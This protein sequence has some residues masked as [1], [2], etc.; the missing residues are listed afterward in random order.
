MNI[1][2]FGTYEEGYSRNEIMIKSLE[3]LGHTVQECHVSFWRGMTDKTGTMSGK[4]NR[5]RILFRILFIYPRLFVKYIFTRQHDLVFVGYF[6]HLDMIFLRLFNLILFRQ[7][8]IVFDVFLSLYDSMIVDRKMD[9]GNSMLARL[10]KWLDKTAC[11]LADVVILD[12]YRHIEFF[13]K[14][15]DVPREKMF[16]VYASADEDVF[17]PRDAKKENT[18]FRVLFYGKYIPLHGIEHIVDAAELLATDPEIRFTLIG[19]GQLYPEIRR[20]VADRR[21]PNIDFIEWVNYENLPNHIASADVCLGIFSSS[22]KAARVIP[23]KVFQ[24]MA[25]GKAVITG[26]TPGSEEGLVDRENVLLCNVADAEDLASTIRM[27]QHD[28]ALKKKI[29]L[30]ARQTFNSIFGNEAVKSSLQAIIS[31]VAS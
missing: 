1:C 7:K 10:A 3:A 30:N 21:L 17:Y 6:G 5:A 22:E 14:V 8:K 13:H 28:V 12:T 2:Y 25:M 24:A 18:S 31:K 26:R 23:N 15:F 19:R 9:S 27:L 29:E 20:I 16:R 11:R 4:I